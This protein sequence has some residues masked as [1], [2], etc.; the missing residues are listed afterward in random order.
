M[1]RGEA[2]EVPSQLPSGFHGE[3]Q[4]DIKEQEGHAELSQNMDG[5]AIF[6]DFEA[7][8]A[9]DYA[10]GEEADDGADTDEAAGEN[11]EESCCEQDDR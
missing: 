8:G 3:M 7:V 2:E 11:D 1:Q 9:E 10:C 6:K 5:F 4:A